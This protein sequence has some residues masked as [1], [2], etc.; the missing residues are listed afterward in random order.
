MKAERPRAAQDEPPIIDGIPPNEAQKRLATFFAESESKQV[1]FLD[2]AAKRII[3]LTTALLGVLFAVIA[4]GD[5]FPPPYLQ[6]NPLAKF[7]GVVTLTSYVMS[8][9][10]AFRAVQPRD[11]KLYRSNLDGMRDELDKI[12]RDKKQPLWLAGLLFWIGSVLL[13]LLIGSIIFAA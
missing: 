12:L 9:L 8:M 2:G 6:G 13:A 7:L 4:F 5:K 10:L 3:E 11:Y 1:E